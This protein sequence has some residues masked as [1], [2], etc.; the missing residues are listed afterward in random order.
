MGFAP[1]SIAAVQMRSTDD[2][3]AN[4]ATCRALAAR[5]ADAGAQIIVLPECFAFL[6]R[7]EGDKSVLSL[8]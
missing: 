4:L 1:V 3:A 5:A 7:R 6:G 8:G 2:L